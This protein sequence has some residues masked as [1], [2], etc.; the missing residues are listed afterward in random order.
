MA[1]FR[2][3]TGKSVDIL[4]QLHDDEFMKRHGFY[5]L[6]MFS[7]VEIHKRLKTY[8]KFLVVRHP[9]ERL[10]SAYREKFERDFNTMDPFVKEYLPK[11]KLHG[12]GNNSD[13]LF[14]DFI[15]Y[16]SFIY[17]LTTPFYQKPSR[18]RLLRKT[19]KGFQWGLKQRLNKSHLLPKGSKYFNEHW[20]QYSTLCHPCHIDYDYVGKLETM[21]E[22]AAYVLSKLGPHDQC[23][24][25]KY[26]ELF[27]VTESSSS[28]FDSYFST[29]EPDQ[30]KKLK[31][32]FSVDFKL[33]GYKE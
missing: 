14:T 16:I 6:K 13:V 27:N 30:I 18:A 19:A 8:F 9:F 20:A 5:R 29:L 22:D 11:I 23:I 31:K 32:M 26:P 4:S 7:T 17:N 1:I 25:D 24:Q 21:R 15:S 33:F 2:S 10:L 3:V 28:L 12:K